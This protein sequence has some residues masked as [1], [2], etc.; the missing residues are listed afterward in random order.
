MMFGFISKLPRFGKNEKGSLAPVLGVAAIPIFM[1][2]GLA[3]DY[4]NAVSVQARLQAA[5][6]AAA[7]AAGR[8]A[9]KSNA[10]LERIAQDYFHSNFGAPANA[11]TP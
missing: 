8:E 10:E 1:A 5:V 6:D 3:V 9:N 11:G 7:L 4:G 2:A